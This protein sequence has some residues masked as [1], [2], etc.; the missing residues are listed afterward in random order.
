MNIDEKQKK[1]ELF[2]TKYIKNEPGAL[3]DIGVGPKSEWKVLG[4]FYKNMSIFGVEA[5]PDMCKEILNSGFN[6]VLLNK[7]VSPHPGHIELRLYRSDGLDA[8]MLQIDGRPVSKKYS[9]PTITLDEADSIFGF[10]DNVI[11]WMDIEGAELM[12]LQSGDNLLKSGRV[13]WINLEVRENPPWNGGC[14][15]SEIDVHL[16]ELGY[17]KATEY[18]KHPHV[19][20]YDVIYVKSEISRE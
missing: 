14:K 4:D 19:G 6:G 20:H 11:L 18:N 3:Y 12:A 7:A 17:E 1:L 13:K 2:I 8:S 5:N 9:I 10:K 15:A 16:T